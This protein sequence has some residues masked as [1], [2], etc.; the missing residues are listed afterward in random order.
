MHTF[1]IVN[2]EHGTPQTPMIE[3]AGHSFLSGKQN[4]NGARMRRGFCVMVLVPVVN[5]YL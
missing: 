1:Y 3:G 5:H 4:S 2:S